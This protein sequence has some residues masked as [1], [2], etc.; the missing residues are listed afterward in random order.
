[1]KRTH[2]RS[3]RVTGVVA[4]FL[5]LIVLLAARFD[6]FTAPGTPAPPT[7]A[8]GSDT[9]GPT[10]GSPNTAPGSARARE[11][12]ELV[13]V[14]PRRD[15]VNGY[16]RDCGPDDACVFGPSWT[17]DTDAPLSRNGCDTRNDMLALSLDQVQFSTRSPDCD[18]VGG[19]LIDPYT[20][21]SMDYATQ[22]SAI[23]IDH[24]YPLA[25]AWDLGAATWSPRERATFANDTELELLAVN[26]SAN[27]SKGD[28]TPAS[29]LPPS[30]SFRCTYVTAYLE[31]AHAYDLAITEADVRVIEPVLRKA[32]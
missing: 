25:A 18:V 13:R 7:S 6:L 12:L 24:L 15:R 4:A 8:S 21:V 16:D 31:V 11:L 32:C 9:A 29:W 1:M 5:A 30:K 28:S 26:G 19:T 14:V 3:L 27:L 2:H 10:A 20:D 17:D 22:A 23:H